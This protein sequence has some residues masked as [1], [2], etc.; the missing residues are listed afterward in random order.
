MIRKGTVCLLG[1]KRMA[2]RF[3][4]TKITHAISTQLV[5]AQC[6]I[7]LSATHPGKCLRATRFTTSRILRLGVSFGESP[8]P[9]HLPPGFAHGGPMPHEPKRRHSLGGV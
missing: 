4:R 6:T 3:S 8:P 2:S 7:R 1:T 9:A 5:R